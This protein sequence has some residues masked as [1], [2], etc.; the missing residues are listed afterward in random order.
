MTRYLLFLLFTS[1][2]SAQDYCGGAHFYDSGG[3]DGPYQN[4]ENTTTVITPSG[5]GDRVRAVFHQFDLAGWGDFMAI[6]DGP[7]F[8]GTLLYYGD[9][10]TPPVSVAAM[11]P[12]G[13]LTFVFWTNGEATAAGW[14]ATIICEPMPACEIAPTDLAAENITKNSATVGWTDGFGGNTWEYRLYPYGSPPAEGNGITTTQNPMVFEGL[15][16][17]ACYDFYVRSDCFEGMSSWVGPLT[18][19]ALPDY[20]GGDHFYDS[21]GADGHYS[22]NEMAITTI[23]PEVPGERIRAEFALFDTDSCCDLLMVYNGPDASFPLLFHSAS[24]A[25]SSVASTHESGALTFYFYSDGATTAEGWDATILCEPMP[26]CANPP[27]YLDPVAAGDGSAQLGWNDISGASQ[28]ELEVRKWDEPT[29]GIPTHFADENPVMVTD[30]LPDTSYRYYVRA[31]CDT[32]TSAWSIPYYFMTGVV[33]CDDMFYDPGGPSSYYNPDAYMVKIFFP[34]EEGQKV[35]AQFSVFDLDLG[36]ALAIY[37]G[38]SPNHPLLYYGNFFSPGTVTSSHP[39]GALTID[40]SSDSEYEG[41]GWAAHI[42]CTALDTES[43]ALS[44]LTCY[45]NPVADRLR[46]D[47]REAISSIAIHSLDGRLV[48][49]ATEP[50][51]GSVNV[52]HLVAGLYLVTFESQEAS[53]T[54]RILK[55]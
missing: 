31:V 41:P 3:P 26:E 22:N 46:Y 9:G 54:F 38:P 25:P 19:C 47:S 18:F 23:F 8:N 48:H 50:G 34:A 14:D 16:P 10:S 51:K 32:N 43:H 44:S 11:H 42:T 27:D 7:D 4:S 39:T 15:T 13:A 21:G 55:Q 2:L 45:P 5:P 52:S 35:K 17:G 6:Y 37:D 33:A 30:L 53:K 28:W 36:D 40:F 12:S 24:G 49:R 29:T 1:F 20:C